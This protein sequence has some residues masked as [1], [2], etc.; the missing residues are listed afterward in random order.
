LACRKISFYF[1]YLS[2]TLSIIIKSIQFLL[3]S[4]FVTI[5]F[6]LC[7]VVSPTPHALLDL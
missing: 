4:T 6:L 1:S 2:P 3:C 5:S 7:G